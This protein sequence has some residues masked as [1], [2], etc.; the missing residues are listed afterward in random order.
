M[1]RRMQR[2]GSLIREV[3]A[4]AIQRRLSDPRIP[5]LTSITRVEVAPDLTVAKVF[6]SVMGTDGQQSAAVHALDAATGRLRHE[7]AAATELRTTPELVFRLDNS[8]Q[9]GAATIEAIDEAMRELGEAPPW[10]Q[11]ES[12]GADPDDTVPEEQERP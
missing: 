9:T 10:E 6:I 8:L 7:I 4:D 2:V 11:D 5:P 3:L 1:S 12:D